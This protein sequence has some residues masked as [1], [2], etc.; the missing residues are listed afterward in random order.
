[1]GLPE[2]RSNY[3]AALGRFILSFNELDN[4]LTEIIETILERLKAR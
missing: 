1:M 2:I 4:L 3:E